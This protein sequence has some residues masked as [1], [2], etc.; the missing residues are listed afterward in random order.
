MSE[1]REELLAL[2]LIFLV[3]LISIC[4]SIADNAAIMGGLR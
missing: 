3:F 1:R 4:A 2:L